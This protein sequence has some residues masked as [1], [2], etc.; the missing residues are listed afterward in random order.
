MPP[1]VIVPEDFSIAEGYFV[2]LQ[3]NAEDQDGDRLTY[4]SWS[5]TGGPKVEF[6]NV[7][8]ANSKIAYF[9]APS[10]SSDTDLEFTL[11][12]S[13]TYGASDCGSVTITVQS[14]D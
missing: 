3:G 13:D 7:G 1:R 9:T 8:F 12:V 11:C 10:V 5:Q 6:S 4:D 2:I 14:N